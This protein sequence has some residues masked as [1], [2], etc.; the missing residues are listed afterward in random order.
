MVRTRVTT[1]TNVKAGA[2]VC[3]CYIQKVLHNT[4]I[5]KRPTRIFH[6]LPMLLA[7]RFYPNVS[8]ATFLVSRFS[9]YDDTQMYTFTSVGTSPS[10]LSFVQ[11][12]GSS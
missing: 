10:S 9:R 8:T 12:I 3:T 7:S 11:H 2:V 6:P 5:Q 1:S 4:S